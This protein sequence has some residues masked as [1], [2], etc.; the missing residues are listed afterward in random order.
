QIT[1]GGGIDEGTIVVLAMNFYKGAAQLAQQRD[2]GR[3]VVHEY[4]A[5][6]IGRLNAPKNHV[7]VVIKSVL[8]EKPTGRVIDGNVEYSCHCP[9]SGAVTNQR[10]IASRTKREG[11][12][13]EKNRLAR[14]GLAGKD[15][16]TRQEIDLEPF[17]QDDI[18]D[19]KVRQHLAADQLPAIR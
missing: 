13:I 10:G 12:R 19:R 14:T 2:A 4:A 7:A 17:D 18:A 8:T 15:R 5:A 16:Q 1:V 9:L 3:L 11:K 6:A